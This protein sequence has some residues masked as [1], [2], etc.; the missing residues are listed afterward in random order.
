[1]LSNPSNPILI[2]TPLKCRHDLYRA[3]GCTVYAKGRPA[4]NTLD[5]MADLLREYEVERV[6]CADWQLGYDDELAVTEVFTDL[7]VALQR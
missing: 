6:V 4:P 2:T 3:L 7:H 1:M 5:A